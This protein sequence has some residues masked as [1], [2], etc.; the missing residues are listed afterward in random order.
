MLPSE[1]LR[2]QM[3]QARIALTGAVATDLRSQRQAVGPG[4]DADPLTA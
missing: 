4:F 2:R 3:L 1:W